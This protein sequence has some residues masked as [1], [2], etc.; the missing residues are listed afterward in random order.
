M[1]NAC[2][3]LLDD[4]SVIENFGH[5]VRRGADQLHAALIRLVMWLGADEGWQER[6]INID[7]LLRVVADKA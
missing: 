1:G 7:D 2:H 6:V 3:A 5:I 4:G